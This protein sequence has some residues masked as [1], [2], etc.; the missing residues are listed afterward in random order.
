MSTSAVMPY[1]VRR[2]RKGTYH[3]YRKVP[4]E[5]AHL[6]RRTH[7]SQSLKTSDIKEALERGGAL[8]DATERY[9]AALSAGESGN[10]PFERYQAAVQI[11]QSL[12]FTYRRA[13]EVAT[14]DLAEL[15]RRLAIA[16]EAF[17][18]SEAVVHAMIGTAPEPAPKLSNL[19]DLYTANNEDGLMGMSENQLGKHLVSRR[20]A[21]A[22]VT[23]VLGDVELAA[24]DRSDVLRFR[25]WW[26][27]KVKRE[28]LTA[29]SANRSFSD[30]KGMLTVIDTALHT[31][32]HK[33]WE[34]VRLK[35]T[36]A[37]KL[38]KRPP[39]PAD[40]ISE[41]VLAEGALDT[42]NDEARC[43]VLTMIETGMRLGEVCNL[44]PQ[45]IRLGGDVP[46]VEV[47]EREDRRQK[48]EH[49]IRRV[50][51]VGVALWAMKR[52]PQGFPRYQDKADSAS[53]LINKV[54]DTAG[55]RPTDRHT[56]YSFRH[57]FQDRIENAGASDRM[58]ADLMGHEFG[59]PS[60]GDGAEMQRRKDLLEQI[61]FKPAWLTS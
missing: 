51:L 14:L 43:I 38:K 29:Y 33:P 7:V 36:N 54:M 11:A 37:T 5:V 25:D 3:Y 49:S 30:I 34:G 20:R 18:K 61:A 53:A 16:Q 44:R 52:H 50:P 23:D 13:A 6:D 39:F 2:G 47:A 19:I 9:W 55:L 58:Q 17:G 60:Y 15:D 35:E 10:A 59:R 24:I 46:H 56:V 41:K 57:S 27:D 26:R 21:V 4:R 28:K 8:H 22:Y 45:D 1:L 40:W 31:S 32:F 12:G 48:T 42:M